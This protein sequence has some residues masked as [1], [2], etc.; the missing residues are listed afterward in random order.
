MVLLLSNQGIADVISK[1][2]FHDI[3]EIG[4]HFKDIKLD[5]NSETNNSSSYGLFVILNY[6]KLVL[7]IAFYLTFFQGGDKGGETISYT[8]DTRYIFG[9][10]IEVYNNTIPIQQSGAS[11]SIYGLTNQ[12]LTYNVSLSK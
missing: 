4:T 2:I 3:S 12:T 1:L 10:F 9:I 8:L 6:I 5:L 11:V 7:H